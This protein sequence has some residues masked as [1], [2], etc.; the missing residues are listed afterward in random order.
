MG[1]E[2]INLCVT[3]LAVLVRGWF[4]AD[5]QSFSFFKPITIELYTIKIY[6]IK[7]YTIKIY[8]RELEN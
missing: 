3:L 4:S 5:K 6:T 2:S 7:I 1:A 8:T